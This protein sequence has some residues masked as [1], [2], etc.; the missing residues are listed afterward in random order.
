[1]QIHLRNDTFDFHI[2][3][4]TIVMKLPF[5]LKFA[6]ILFSMTQ[7]CFGEEPNTIENIAPLKTNAADT[8][9]ASSQQLT[10]KSATISNENTKNIATVPEQ[11]KTVI[12]VPSPQPNGAVEERALKESRIPPDFF[13]ITFYKPTYILPYYYTGSPYQ[14]V[15][16]NMTPNDE[17]I[18][19][20][21]LKYQLSFKVP[22]WRKVFHTGATLY[23]AYTQLSYWQA[24]NKNAFFRETDYEPELFLGNE[25]N[26]K[27]F[28]SWYIN[29]LNIGAV[30]QSNGFGG[31]MERSW[32]RIYLEAVSSMDNLMISIKPWIIFY[33]C[34]MREH[35][36]NIAN[37]LGYGQI[38]IAYKFMDHVFTLQTHNLFESGGKR[39]TAEFSWSFPITPFVDGYIQIF[40]GYG[41]SLIEYNHRTNS[42]GIGITLS[43]WI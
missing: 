11:P 4:V 43:N 40:S 37:Y 32:N 17:N 6:C 23:L 38:L 20:S 26:I 30:H 25:T 7:L 18:Q 36:A 13:A 22:I 3:I 12:P 19:R 15:Y 33:D 41:Q 21:E 39:V 1:M 14:S 9:A 24:Y 10:Q 8:V 34:T 29:F 42:A 2:G 16:N 35:N 28:R 27:L 5:K 31:S